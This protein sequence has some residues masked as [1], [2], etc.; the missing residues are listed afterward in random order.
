MDKALIKIG[1][2]D[3]HLVTAVEIK[4]QYGAWAPRGIVFTC[5]KC[6]QPVTPC[7]MSSGSLQSPHF[8]H[9]EDNEKAR[10]CELYREGMGEYQGVNKPN[11]PLPMFIRRSENF[12]NQ[13][14]VEGGFCHL[15][16]DTLAQLQSEHAQIKTGN[17]L[18]DVNSRR[19]GAGLT[20][21][22]FESI[23][24]NPSQDVRLINSSL[25]LESIWGLP[26]EADRAMVFV[27]NNAM[28]GRRLRSGESV[29]AGSELLLLAPL[30]E[31]GA[32]ERAFS[33]SRKI[34]FAGSLVGQSRLQVFHVV[35]SLSG[36]PREREA[37]YLK[38]CHLH[39]ADTVKSPELLWPP[40]L[41]ED[42]A[43]RPLSSKGCIFGVHA[44]PGG[45]AACS[46]LPAGLPNQI[47]TFVLKSSASDE[48]GYLALPP[49]DKLTR[50]VM[51]KPDSQ[52][53][54]V[55]LDAS[56]RIPA[57]PESDTRDEVSVTQDGRILH[58]EARVPALV[59]WLRRG[60][61][62]ERHKLEEG[63]PFVCTIGPADYIL[64][65]RKL[66]HSGGYLT[67][68]KHLPRL[69][70]KPNVEDDMLSINDLDRRASL[71]KAHLPRD[72]K[73]AIARK[74]MHFQVH[75]STADK[76]FARRRSQL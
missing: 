56:G 54:T 41:V 16:K 49:S 4:R 9:V 40:S 17:R 30:G 18:Y 44:T 21:I 1:R 34:G 63:S 37:A 42:G 71:L 6:G 2:E 59:L 50:L 64:V 12:L 76:D 67:L 75:M 52:E 33:C 5:P 48:Y 73:F 28:Q 11:I 10:Q 22:P 46:E 24:L 25:Q 39:I 7:A 74:D 53:G 13:F 32:I 23:S 8:R 27:C 14:V 19:F 38:S 35:L 58:L 68:W 55:L 51:T 3:P 69:S 29:E 26:E 57:F 47:K 45:T 43:V 62:W 66:V 15:D 31:E 20:R 61:P 72:R 36:N 60:H 65:V 70:S